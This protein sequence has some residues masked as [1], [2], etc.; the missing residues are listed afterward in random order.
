MAP[1]YQKN[2]AAVKGLRLSEEEQRRHDDGG[3]P[4]T[5]VGEGAQRVVDDEAQK[6]PPLSIGYFKVN[7][8]VRMQA[9]LGPL[10][11][12]A[13]KPSVTHHCANKKFSPWSRHAE[14][15]NGEAFSG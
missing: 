5:V 11:F 6:E 15:Q 4:E 1:K 3:E 13:F 8:A 10:R 9:P 12:G 14:T 2:A 7:A